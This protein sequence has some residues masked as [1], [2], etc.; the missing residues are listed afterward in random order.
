MHRSLFIF[1]T[2]YAILNVL[3]L[4]CSDEN[5]RLD[6]ALSLSCAVILR[7]VRPRNALNMKKTKVLRKLILKCTAGNCPDRIRF[8]YF[9]DK[10]FE[11]D[12]VN[13]GTRD[14]EAL[15]RIIAFFFYFTAEK[16]K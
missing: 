15:K 8:E 11:I 10:T 7:E 4:S 16:K 12:G 14:G 9:S 13:I 5:G 6:K 1:P 2:G 3:S